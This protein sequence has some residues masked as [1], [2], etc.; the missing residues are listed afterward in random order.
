MVTDNAKHVVFLPGVDRILTPPWSVEARHEAGVLLR[1]LQDGGVLSMPHSRPMPSIG[2]R[3][4]EL[5]IV[6]TNV[7]WR[8]IYRI[9]AEDIVVIHTFGKKTQ[10]TPQ[11]VIELCQRRLNRY[12]EAQ[13][14]EE[15]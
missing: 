5:R 4:H 15:D 7:T 11:R 9:D 10:Q 8:V 13:A 1:E 14:K 2:R 6:D 3:C 12:D